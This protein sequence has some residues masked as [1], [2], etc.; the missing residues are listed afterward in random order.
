[1]PA[2]ASVIRLMPC[3]ADTGAA[4]ATQL[5]QMH[6][7]EQPDEVSTAN[8]KCKP[9]KPAKWLAD[10]A[11]PLLCDTGG[12]SMD[13]KYEEDL[14]SNFV[15]SER[16][17]G[18]RSVF[19]RAVND[20][21]FA[22]LSNPARL[23]FFREAFSGI[24]EDKTVV[25]LGTG[26]GQ[27]AA[28]CS[29]MGAK[30]VLAVDACSEMCEL[31]RETARRNRVSQAVQ[32]AHFLS[33]SLALPDD[34]RADVLVSEPYDLFITGPSG[35]GSL[36]Y[37]IDA[38]QRLAKPTATLIPSGGAQY[39][40]LLMSHDLGMRTM[41]E[42]GSSK[43]GLDN[44]SEFLDTVT[45]TS[46]RTKGFRW[47]CLPGLTFM[48]GR[49]CLFSLDFYKLKRSSIPRKA[50]VDVQVAECLVVAST[51]KILKI[52]SKQLR[53]VRTNHS[54]Q[55]I[56]SAGWLCRCHCDIL[57]GCR[58]SHFCLD[59]NVQWRLHIIFITLPTLF[60]Q[61]WAGS[62]G[63]HRFAAHAEDEALAF[64]VA[65]MLSKQIPAKKPP[66]PHSTQA[67]PYSILLWYTF[68]SLSSSDFPSRLVFALTNLGAEQT[69]AFH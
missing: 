35:S 17:R 27:L 45:L 28:L 29:Q 20:D 22:F 11:L 68:M 48:S 57:G 66:F 6:A 10:A 41:S 67:L 51:L 13:A 3:Q 15:C 49:C 24:V 31:A 56:G 58:S 19:V 69:L 50:V 33:S 30:H 18:K 7:N 61:V 4:S 34:N 44:L 37:F 23:N 36:E 9:C 60:G 38:R 2:F 46:S 25:D 64:D 43:V 12:P 39:A 65:T 47:T 26:A 8:T 1:M 62:A 52:L 32:V 14:P 59:L 54:K 55:L 42:T 53:D 21:Y 40:R 63:E 16:L 5:S